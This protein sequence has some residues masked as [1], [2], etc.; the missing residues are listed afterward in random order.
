MEAEEKG[1]SASIWVDE[2]GFIAEGPNF[3]V[4]FVTHHKEL[5]L[6]FFDKI[7][8]GCTALRLLELATKLVEQG[9]LKRVRTGNLT[10]EEAKG[11]AEMMCCLDP[12]LKT[13]TGNKDQ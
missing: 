13:K 1:A 4:A 9:R 6:P 3:N 12:N 11:A 8:S 5:V 10:V 2:E 7:L